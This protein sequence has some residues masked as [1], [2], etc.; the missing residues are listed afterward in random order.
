ME[1]RLLE[2]QKKQ[3]VQLAIAEDRRLLEL[4]GA[5]RQ[6]LERRRARAVVLETGSRVLFFHRYDGGR[7]RKQYVFIGILRLFV[8]FPNAF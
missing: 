8:R 3:R 6:L 4:A 1:A 7:A 2:E 5:T